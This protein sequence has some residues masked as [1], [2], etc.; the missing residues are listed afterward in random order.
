[1]GRERCEEHW[2]LIWSAQPE[3]TGF[4]FIFEIHSPSLTFP[5]EVTQLYWASGSETFITSW[6]LL[7]KGIAYG[8]AIYET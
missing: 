4:S 3:Q 5:S 7:L 8:N 6:S 2:V 1:M